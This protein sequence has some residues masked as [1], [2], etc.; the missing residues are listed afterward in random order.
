ME[1]SGENILFRGTFATTKP[2]DIEIHHNPF[3]QQNAERLLFEVTS[4]KTS[5]VG[6]VKM[7][8]FKPIRWK[9]GVAGF[10]GGTSAKPFTDKKAATVFSD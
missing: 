3:E 9:S 4:C 5:G 1:G 7:H 8:F 2:D 10:I 6:S